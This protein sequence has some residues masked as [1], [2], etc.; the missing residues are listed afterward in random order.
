M[1][2]GQLQSYLKRFQMGGDWWELVLCAYGHFVPY[3]IVG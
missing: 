1:N 3:S 2:S